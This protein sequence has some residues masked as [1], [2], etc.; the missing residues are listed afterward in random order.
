MSINLLEPKVY[1]RISAGEVVERPASI[2]KELVENSIDAGA[3]AISVSIEN[4]GITKIEVSDNGCGIE[5]DDLVL[6]FTPHATSKIKT[7]EDLDAIGSLGFRGEALASIASVCHVHL[8]S[9]YKDSEV[10]YS[11]KVDGGV[12]GQVSEVAR[13]SGTTLTCRDLFFNT[14]ARAKFLRKPKSEEGEVTHLIEK[15][16]LSHPEIAFSYFVDN[17]QVYNTT[18]SIMSDIIY[19]IYGREVYDCLIP[20]SHEENGI[21][22]KGYVT[23]PKIS[24]S[25]RTFQTLFVN[26]RYVE[27]YLVSQAVQGVYESFL[28]KGRFP[29]YVLELIVPKDSVD[30][31]VHPS[32]REVKFDNNSA[33]FGLVRRAVEKALLSVDQIANFVS[34][35]GENSE[36]EGKELSSPYNES[37]FNPALKPTEKLSQTEGSS[38]KKVDHFDSNEPL[39]SQ[40]DIFVPE[41]QKVQQKPLPP[42]FQN[43]KLPEREEP[44]NR[45]GG[46]FFFDQA[47]SNTIGQIIAEKN[48]SFLT[49]NVKDEMHILG[50][51]FKT[52][53]IIECNDSIYFIDQ[54]AGHERLLYD[55][56]L[57]HINDN[58][59]AKQTLLMPYKFTIGPKES[60]SLE[61]SI[62]YLNEIGFEIENANGYTY[63]IKSV[64]LVL[65]NINLEKFVDEVVKEGI[66]FDKKP[67]EFIHDR[68]C[69]SAC[70]H[71]IK[72]GDTITNDECAYI[73]EQIRKGVML[74]PHGRPVVLEVTKH[75]F[76]K[77]FKRIV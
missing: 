56:L 13:T 14:P 61:R 43:I 45:M 72:A 15:F 29:I 23:K 46:P 73:I 48:N 55:K 16:M 71:A 67:S 47:K 20:V 32:K 52:Y 27:N 53:I 28:M 11:L 59:I 35:Y 75:E 5:K 1:N 41:Y 6:A 31:N 30:V 65:S 10:G 21:S 22:L 76:E 8:T 74:C 34:S 66:S 42:D 24:K 9:R 44:V 39:I 57:K 49:A 12:F 64:P 63:E 25:N 17:K 19:T 62:N 58:N 54:H 3:T 18:S 60:Q 26:G 77:M 68:L 4:G 51:I 50:T 69:Q 2:V 33:I 36:I 38:Y 40:K 37:G 7:I 70:K